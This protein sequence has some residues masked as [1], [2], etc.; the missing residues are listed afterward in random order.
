M[1]AELA[2]RGVSRVDLWHGS[3][4][5]AQGDD[6]SLYQRWIALGAIARRSSHYLRVPTRQYQLR[7]GGHGFLFGKTGEGDTWFQLERH[8]DAPITVHPLDYL[9]HR[10]DYLR[11][12]LSGQNVGPLGFSPRT[13]RDPLRIGWER[14]P[15]GHS[16]PSP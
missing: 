1:L 9:G 7:F 15:A 16:T 3:H 2:Q 10:L 14:L 8:A 12:R 11:Y 6:G 4:L 13:D 5:I